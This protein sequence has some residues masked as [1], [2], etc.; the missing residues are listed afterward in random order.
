MRSVESQPTAG[1]RRA[2]GIWAQWP[3]GARWTNE[4]M[5]RLLGF[6][7]EGIARGGEFVFRVVLP[8]TIR[9]DAERD[10]RTLNAELGRD[11]TLHSPRDVSG[12]AASIAELAAFA[13]EHV[14]VEA[15]LTLFPNFSG[16]KLLDAPVTVIFPDAIPKVFHEFGYEA[17][18]PEGPHY[19]WESDIRDLL[20]HASRAITFSNHVASQHVH[21]LFDFPSEQ[22]AVLEHAAPDLEPLLPYMQ[23][24]RRTDSSRRRAAELL[25]DECAKRAQPYLRDYPFE[26][27]PYVAVSTQDRVTKNIQLVAR[28]LQLLVRERRRDLKLLMTAPLH[29]E[30]HWT[31]L[32]SV[33]EEALSHFD[34]ISLPDL[35]REEHA[36]FLHCAAVVVHPSIFE[37]G[38]APFPFYEAVSVGTPCLMA[39]GPHIAELAL[40]EPAIREFC[41]DPNDAD[42][43]ADLIVATLSKRE[44]TIAAQQ[45]IY[46]RLRQSDWTSVARAYAET[47]L[48][49]SAAPHGP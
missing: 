29:F 1:S 3:K 35:P 30:E 28:A 33:V 37:G 11:F 42:G 41:F 5:T 24:R 22:I 10:L 14:P 27:V 12:S 40:T 46:A 34:V 26:Q 2:V 7:L 15:W 4:G 19:Q 17:W 44:E 25:R 23:G 36:A 32:P 18:G 43:L 21:E 38:H 8:D 49:R 13:N 6:L 9:G 31:A 47:A 16:A 39:Y 20:S 45:E 48:R